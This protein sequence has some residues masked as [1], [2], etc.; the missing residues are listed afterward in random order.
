[1]MGSRE[2]GEF[3][4]FIRVLGFMIILVLLW[5]NLNDGGF[6]LFWVRVFCIL[7]NRLKV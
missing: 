4:I 1:M 5:F 7:K 3:I 2:L 6:G